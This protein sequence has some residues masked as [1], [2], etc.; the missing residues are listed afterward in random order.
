MK[1]PNRL[2][3]EKSPYLL[4]HAYNPVNWYP[5]GEEAFKKAENEGKPV[6]LSIGYSTCH[7]CHVMEKESFE[8]DEVAGLMNDFFVSIKVDREERPDIDG[9]YMLVCQMLT[10]N[11]GWPLTIVMTPDKKPFFAGTYFPKEDRFGRMGM[12]NLIPAIGNIWKNKREE[13]FK[14]VNEI[15]SALNSTLI[16]KN[17]KEINEEILDKAFNYFSNNFDAENGGFGTSPKFPTPHNLLFLL[18]YW[19]RKNSTKAL[20]MVEKTLTGMYNGGIFDHIGFGFHRYSTDKL[21][22]VPHFEKMIYDQALITN[23]FIEAYQAAEKDIYK[24]AAAEILNYVMRDMASPDGGFYSAEDADSE[25]EEGK[26][27][28]WTKEEIEN[29]LNNDEAEFFSDFFNIKAEGNWLD[30]VHDGKTG[31]NILHLNKEQKLFTDEFNSD[32]KILKEK[33]EILREKLFAVREKRVRPF[34]DTKILTDWNGL[35]ISALSK[36]AQVFEKKE[37]YSAAGKAS[38]FI[39]KNV[40]NDERRLLH[41]FKDGESSVPA[42]AD[43]YAFLIAGLLDLYEAGFD[44][45]YLKTAVDLNNDF[46]KYFWDDTDGGFYFT[47]SDGEKLLIRQKEIYDGAVPSANSVALLNLLRIGRITGNSDYEKKASLIIKNFSA[48]IWNSPQAFTQTLA[49]LDFAFGPSKEIIISE[50]EDPLITN[51][52]LKILREKYIPNKVIVFNSRK[53][54]M[55]I[56]SPLLKE[57]SSHENRTAVYICENYKCNLPAATVEQLRNMLS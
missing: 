18:R 31:T 53:D 29:I 12:L 5:W 22:L 27:Y 56:I 20:D 38:A 51:E 45:H 19:K 7:W 25:G 28:L 21:W 1:K 42:N 23:V 41:R 24:E 26:F 13:I 2:I 34:K 37:Y 57:Y 30:P 49:A 17:G 35:M 15:T 52:M 14:S 55:E 40:V 50:G 44:S 11:G 16:K 39:L 4:Q 36:A 54:K 6:F 32:E 10:G 43:D 9:I 8:D 47:P 3:N 33:L 46:I 48:M